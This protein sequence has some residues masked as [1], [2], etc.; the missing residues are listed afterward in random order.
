VTLPFIPKVDEKNRSDEDSTSES[1]GHLAEK[2]ADSAAREGAAAE[3]DGAQPYVPTPCDACEGQRLNP[4]ALAVRLRDLSIAAADRAAGR[5]MRSTGWAKWSSPGA[6]P[7][8]RATCWWRSAHA[9]A[10][11]A[12]SA[13]AT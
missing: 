6:R 8:S 5:R 7:R 13:S 3:A 4:T 10:S 11:W 12:R 9:C 2:L 1:I